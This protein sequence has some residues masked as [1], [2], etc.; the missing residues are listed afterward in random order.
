M[1]RRI[2][3][4]AGAGGGARQARVRAR[5]FAALG[6]ETRLSLVV[7]LAMG[8]SR[9]IAQLTEGRGVTRQAITRHLR[10]LEGAGIVRG[11][12]RGRENLFELDPRPI[13]ELREYL[14]V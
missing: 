10:V 13:V 9:S 6:D 2:R 8:E 14:G 7:N 4:R 12:R 11:V 1:S 5:I 3:R